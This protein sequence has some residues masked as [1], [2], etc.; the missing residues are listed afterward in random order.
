MSLELFE[1]INFELKNFTNQ[2]SY[3]IVGDPLAISNLSDYLNISEKANLKV[4]ITTAGTYKFDYKLL[5]HPTI[6]QINFSLNSFN[7][8]NLNISLKEYL[9]YIFEFCNFSLNYGERFINLRLWNGDLENSAMEYNR[10]V[11]NLAKEFFG[12][13]IETRVAKKVLF[14]YDNYFEWPNINDNFIRDSGTCYGLISHFGILSNGT[15][16]P[17]CLDKDGVINLG[18]LKTNSLK[19][20]LSSQRAKNIRDGFMKNILNE[21]LC[22]KCRY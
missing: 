19:T 5:T 3:H 4:N 15:V 2:I 18:D 10:A 22:K 6:R 12:V 13:E 7:A 11:L 14:N 17:C 1:K 8:N 9:F 20:I 21:E 16:V